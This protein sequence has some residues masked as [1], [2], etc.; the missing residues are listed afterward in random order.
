[1]MNVVP[2]RQN[3]PCSDIV[4][5]LRLIADEI[6]QG[7]HCASQ[8]PATTAVL[9]LGHQ[10]ERPEGPDVIMSRSNWTTHGFGPRHDVFTVRGLLA[11][12]LGNGFDSEDA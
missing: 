2:L 6:E 11:T 12:V 8:W 10:S 4:A 1:M 5:T 3:A 9:V 7:K